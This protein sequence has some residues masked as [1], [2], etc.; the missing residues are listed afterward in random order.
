MDEHAFNRMRKRTL[1]TDA[2]LVANWSGQMYKAVSTG[3]E[4]K[5]AQLCVDITRLSADIY[6]RITKKLLGAVH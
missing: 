5:A 1:S 6:T 3:E 4:I 2:E